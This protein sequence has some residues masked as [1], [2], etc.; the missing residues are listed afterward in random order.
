MPTDMRLRQ[1]N[2]CRQQT[3]SH[4]ACATAPSCFSF[5]CVAN[6]STGP[7]ALLLLR[8]LPMLPLPTLPLLA[9][10][11]LLPLSL[12]L[13]L[14][15]PPPLLLLLPPL[16]LYPAP[17][18][19]TGLLHCDLTPANLLVCRNPD[20][21]KRKKTQNNSSHYHAAAAAAANCKTGRQLETEEAVRMARSAVIR[22]A[23]FEMGGHAH[24]LEVRAGSPLCRL[25]S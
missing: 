18:P 22:L 12:L 6:A 9:L 10:L 3:L 11:A 2:G 16:L 4:P 1:T 13:L 5:P 25:S 14:L 19:P 7:S 17:A 21:K 23:N 8:L 15:L 20:L 24:E